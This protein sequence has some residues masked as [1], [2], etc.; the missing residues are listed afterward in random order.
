[1][2]QNIYHD[3]KHDEGAKHT[4]VIVST[5]GRAANAEAKLIGTSA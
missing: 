2:N 5:A 1:M 3:Y 4:H